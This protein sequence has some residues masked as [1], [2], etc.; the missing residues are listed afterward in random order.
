MRLVIGEFISSSCKPSNEPEVRL[1]SMVANLQKVFSPV[2]FGP[3]VRGFIRSIFLTI[4]A[5]AAFIAPPL[6]S[7]SPEKALERQFKKELKIARV[8]HTTEIL[9]WVGAGL[10]NGY[11]YSDAPN[12]MRY[13]VSVEKNPQKAA[14]YF[15]EAASRGD[16]VSKILLGM[17]YR[18]GNGVEKQL[19][20]AIVL[21][22]E[23]KSGYFDAETEYGIALH[24]VLRSG[25]FVAEEKQQLTK[26]MLHSLTI[27]GAANYLPALNALAQIYDEGVF[28]E[29]DESRSSA[30]R[31]VAK[32]IAEQK[33]A[34]NDA[35][36]AARLRMQQ[37]QKQA[38]GSQ[39][40]FD[41][42]LFLATVGIVG[43]TSLANYNSACTV[44]CNPPSVVDLMNWGVL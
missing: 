33:I 15:R 7:A 40:K 5:I 20:E 42:L 29:R 9:R 10:L 30:L 41:A 38:S 12:G 37:Y 27:G 34:M 44:G 39:W 22:R 43:A 11:V 23:S 21:L 36:A 16:P 2:N 13:F 4:L 19:T 17:M 18:Q 14:D 26:E 25:A 31:D 1:G 28:V 6:V 3:S 8:K 35:L 32:K 24:E